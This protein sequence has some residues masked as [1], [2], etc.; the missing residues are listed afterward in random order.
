MS[1]ILDA[2]Q[3]LFLMKRLEDAGTHTLVV[4]RQ[5]VDR[6]HMADYA[7]FHARSFQ[8]HE[9]FCTRLHFFHRP[10]TPAAFLS[11]ATGMDGDTVSIEGLR[12]SYLGFLVVRPLPRTFIG[13]TCLALPIDEG[14]ATPFL[15]SYSVGLFGIRLQVNGTVAFQ[16]QDSIVAACAT[17]AVWFSLN[18]HGDP[19]LIPSPGSITHRAVPEPTGGQRMFPNRGLDMD[20]IVRALKRERYE[21]VVRDLLPPP[22]AAASG[23]EENGMEELRRAIYAYM[24]GGVAAPILGVHLYTRIADGTVKSFARHAVTVLGYRLADRVPPPVCPNRLRLR[25][26][27]ITGFLVHDDKIGPFCPM[28]IMPASRMAPDT[29]DPP[30]GV[31][32]YALNGF[33][34]VPLRIGRHDPDKLFQVPGLLALATD[35]KIRVLLKDVLSYV[36]EL[37]PYLFDSPETATTLLERFFGKNGEDLVWDIYVADSTT[38][39]GDVRDSL[40]RCLRFAGHE[41][42]QPARNAL[43]KEALRVVTAGWPRYVWRATAYGCQP[44]VPLFD[45]VIDATDVIQ[46]RSLLTPVFYD[47]TLRGILRDML[48]P[49]ENVSDPWWD[50]RR[51]S[52][53]IDGLARH[54]LPP[55]TVPVIDVDALY[56]HPHPPRWVK[57]HERKGDKTFNQQTLPWTEKRCFVLGDQ[58]ANG[59]Q[60]NDEPANDEQVNEEPLSARLQGFLDAL[61][62]ADGFGIWLID[63][64][65]HLVIGE[66]APSV[67][68]DPASPKLGHPTLIGG[69]RARISGELRPPGDDGAWLLTNASGRYCKLHNRDEGMLKEA[70]ALVQKRG[71]ALL[72]DS[73]RV[74]AE[75]V[76]RYGPNRIQTSRDADSEILELIADPRYDDDDRTNIVREW[77]DCIVH[78][79]LTSDSALID[80]LVTLTTAGPSDPAFALR[81]HLI[82]RL[83]HHWPG[84]VTRAERLIPLIQEQISKEARDLPAG[85]HPVLAGLCVAF[86]EA[87]ITML[88]E[89]DIVSEWTDVLSNPL[90]TTV[91]NAR[92]AAVRPPVGGRRRRRWHFRRGEKP[93]S[94]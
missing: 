56:G 39:K 51:I 12:T 38:V 37:K 93:A 10:L 59:E 48:V 68:G 35:H 30:D 16:E 62:A 43:R 91:R 3:F 57:P 64:Y 34:G 69:A 29:G 26:D 92:R 44:D 24:R 80:E 85:L 58:P 65:C 42:D 13:R 81:L 60:A 70:A 52:D 11:M 6:D 49:Y 19:H 41:S 28:D 84:Q 5:Y 90:L 75:W 67:A 86:H 31:L 8:P 87:G 21:V 20:M 71:R 79:H 36:E 78:E 66:D 9:R 32:V 25:A 40:K 15:H 89:L 46:V 23:T 14:W 47:E 77:A 94:P 55:R 50:H 63:E 1:S 45:L 73:F 33:D 18:A 7:H 54:F 88:P 82:G 61:K 17:C 2:A 27:A 22:D 4:E 72:G 53:L 76:D 83:L 74:K